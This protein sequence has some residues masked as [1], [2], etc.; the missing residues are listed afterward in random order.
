M[1][2]GPRVKEKVNP[3]AKEAAKEDGTAEAGTA[4]DGIPDGAMPRE[5]AARPIVY[6]EHKL[7]HSLGTQKQMPAPDGAACVQSKPRTNQ[8]NILKNGRRWPIFR[9]KKRGKHTR[10]RRQM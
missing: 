2:V 7:T 6:S 1:E 10:S 3:E 5:E 4:E 8:Q 9:G